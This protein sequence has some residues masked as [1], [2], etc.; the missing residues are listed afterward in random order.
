MC[1]THPCLIARIMVF[2][3]IGLL[4]A[5]A[6]AQTPP[7][8]PAAAASKTHTKRTTIPEYPVQTD[9]IGSG[10]GGALSFNDHA[11][12][13][14][15]QSFSVRW[16]GD[17]V[18]GIR[19]VYFSGKAQQ[20]GGYDDS[21][22]KQKTYTFR[23]GEVLDTFTLR[24][25]GYGHGSLRSLEFTTS[26]GGHFAVGPGGF[27]NQ[28]N[29]DVKGAALKGF[30]GIRNPDNFINGLGLWISS[31]A[32][33]ILVT[34][35]TYDKDKVQ[36]SKPTMVQLDS[37]ILDNSHGTV[38][39]NLS[40][41]KSLTYTQ[42]GS[43]TNSW[44]FSSSITVSV[45]AGVPGIAS[46]SLSVSATKSQDT[47]KSGALSSSQSTTVTTAQDVPAGQIMRVDFFSSQETITIPFT[48]DMVVKYANGQTRTLKEFKGVYSG[49]TSTEITASPTVEKGKGGKTSDR[50]KPHKKAAD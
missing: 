24:D 35:V 25:S 16:D 13:D 22:Y 38:S 7:A 2:L 45:E 36:R 43:W 30:Y 29:L 15:V 41:S 32:T 1:P 28:V 37:G 19:W 48:C 9:H 21:K 20:V 40:L 10:F 12:D 5:P 49:S 26:R 50:K 6:R 18:R 3:S 39:A 33:E 27:D 42:E 47:S 44:G 11:E 14:S 8:A 23:K 31:P 46:G 17:K 34:H 4:A